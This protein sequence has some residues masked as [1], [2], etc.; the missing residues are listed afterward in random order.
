M[1]RDL[2]DNKNEKIKV[3]HFKDINESHKATGYAYR[4]DLPE[5]HIF[6]LES[7]YPETVKAMPP[8]TKGFYQITLIDNS[9]DVIIG[10]DTNSF[11][12]YET[13]LFFQAPNQTLSW[14]RGKA[15]SG[16]VI[17]FKED[18]LG[19]MQINVCD[20]FPFFNFLEVNYFPVTKEETTPLKAYFNQLLTMFEGNH[21]YRVPMLR[22]LL[23]PLLYHCKAIYDTYKYSSPLPSK[24]QVL[25]ARF[26]CYINQYFIEKKTVEEYAA[27]LHVTAGHLSEVVKTVTGTTAL[28][29]ICDRIITEAKNLIKYTPN[30]IAEIAWRLGFNEPT[31][32]GRFFKR[33]TGTSPASFR[34]A[35]LQ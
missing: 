10:M 1:S 6:T 26:R 14:V 5:F 3:V 29:L 35:N 19:P 9:K 27:L 17:Y 15:Q 31:H 11:Q 4:T 20:E 13:A 2:N 25:V 30:D 21:R 12:N 22:S 8:Y 32:F 34:K 33:E 16:Y 23:F 28:Q 24:K 7:T 18:F